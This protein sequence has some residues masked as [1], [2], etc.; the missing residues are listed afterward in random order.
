[1]AEEDREP[2]QPEILGEPGSIFAPQRAESDI[3]RHPAT[4]RELYNQTLPDTHAPGPTGPASPPAISAGLNG[5]TGPTSQRPVLPTG[6]I[7]P[8]WEPQPYRRPASF[9]DLGGPSEP[10]FQVLSSRTQFGL[11]GVA[12]IGVAGSLRADVTVTPGRE[13]I[14]RT[15]LA[16]RDAILIKS[17]IVRL[18]LVAEIDRA[19]AERSNSASVL[20]LETIQAAVNDL[21][22][23]LSTTTAVSVDVVGEYVD[24]FKKG[25]LDWWDR[26]HVQILGN[27]FNAALF[28]AL[29]EL[30][31]QVGLVQ[32]VTIAAFIKG[33]DV[34]EALKALAKILG[35]QDK[36]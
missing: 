5:P 28:T 16:N 6:P 22:E 25:V 8:I 30:S 4:A 33:K 35:G 12:G 9:V 14:G 26:D 2:S 19:K 23:M 36:D 3:P 13:S 10:P 29:M 1:M 31:A 21:H 11:T 18:L 34:V 20:E 15:A 17:T 32:A 27:S 7:G 24:R